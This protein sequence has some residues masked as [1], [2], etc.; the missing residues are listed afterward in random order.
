MKEDE[1]GRKKIQS[2]DID[3]VGVSTIDKAIVVGE[4]KFKNEPIDKNI[5]DA[6]KAYL[7]LNCYSQHL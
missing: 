5:Y 7:T 2:A 6:G 1:Y 3:V 4:C